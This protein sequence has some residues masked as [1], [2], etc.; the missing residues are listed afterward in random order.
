[1]CG[2]LNS[3]RGWT[4]GGQW[5]PCGRQETRGNHSYSG[6]SCLSMDVCDTEGFSAPLPWYQPLFIMTETF[7]CLP[8]L[9]LPCWNQTLAFLWKSV[10]ADR[11]HALSVCG[12]GR[13]CVVPPRR[14]KSAL[15]CAWDLKLLRPLR[16]KSLWALNTPPLHPCTVLPNSVKNSYTIPLNLPLLKNLCLTLCHCN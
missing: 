8:G 12:W 9:P 6:K 7:H 16:H 3:C 13:W 4:E 2:R 11:S 5:N 1:M 10:L 14:P 15:S